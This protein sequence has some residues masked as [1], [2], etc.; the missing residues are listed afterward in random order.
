MNEDACSCTALHVAA[1]CGSVAMTRLLLDQAARVD[2]REAW[3]ETPLHIAARS[4]S[5]EVC[6]L[7]LDRRADIDAANA[8]GWTPML[9]AA[10]VFFEFSLTSFVFR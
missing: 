3:D 8:D 9:V 2:S 10:E 1:H 6:N 4:G 7:L 5:T